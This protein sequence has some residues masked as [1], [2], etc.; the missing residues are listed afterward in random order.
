MHDF[1]KK[2]KSLDNYRVSQQSYNLDAVFL[3]KAPPNRM[4]N[5][6]FAFSFTTSAK[7]VMFS[8][9]LIISFVC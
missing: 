1:K 4:H 6:P 8:S 7:E 2:N 3:C 5:G 9:A